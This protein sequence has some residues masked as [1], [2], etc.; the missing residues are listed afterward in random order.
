[1]RKYVALLA[2]IVLPT[3]VLAQTSGKISGVVTDE[4][5]APLGGANVLLVGTTQG[6]A[7]DADGQY[8]VMDVQV[9]VY[10]VRAQYIGYK[11]LTVDNLHVSADLT[12]WLD[13]SLEV[14]ALEGEEVTVTAEKPIINLNATNTNRIIDS[15]VIENLPLRNVQALVNLQTGVVDGHVRGSRDGDNA[16]YVDGVL[17]RNQWNGGNITNGIS[18]SGTQEVSVQTGGFS[19]EYGSANG[20]VVNI[21]SKSGGSAWTGSFEYVTDLGSSP[22]TDPDALYSYGYNLLNFDF[23]G[24][25]TKNT[26]F[27]FNVE[28][29]KSLDYEAAYTTHPEADVYELTSGADLTKIWVTGEPWIDGD[30]EN[31]ASEL[32]EGIIYGEMFVRMNQT[33]PDSLVWADGTEWGEGLPLAAIAENRPDWVDTTYIY[34]DNYSRK[35]GPR[36]NATDEKLALTGN[37][38]F[39]LKPLRIKVGGSMWDREVH[40]NNSTYQLLNSDNQP[41]TE[42]GMKLG[43]INGTMTLSPKSFLRTTL[44]LKDY[45]LEEYNPN[46][47]DDFMAYGKRTADIGSVNYYYR[48]HGLNTL[49]IPALVDYD[50]YG[51]QWNR[52]VKRNE[53]TLGIRTDYLNQIGN[54][55][56][57]GGFEYYNTMIRYYQLSQSREIYQAID[58]LDLNFNGVVDP[59]E[60]TA[61]ADIDDWRYNVYR[62][63]YTYNI[64]Y[65]IFGEE[66]DSYKMADHSMEPGKSVISRIFFA[67]KIEFRDVVLNLGI[68]YETFD[69]NTYGPDSDGDGWA[70]DAG[71]DNVTL[72][73]GRVHREGDGDF[74]RNG[75]TRT[76]E[77]SNKWE[78]VEKYTAI[79]PRIGFSFPVTD[80]TVFHAQY[81]H[82][83]QPAPL[84]FLYLSDSRLAANLTQ[85]NQTASPN[86]T[87]RPERTTSYEIGFTQQMGMSAAIDVTGFYKE[88]RDYVMLKNRGDEEDVTALVDG[89]EFSWAQYMNGDFGVTQGFSFNVNLRRM[90]GVMAAFN[91]TAMWARGTGSDP[92]S[93]WNITWTGDTYPSIINR[94]DYDQRHT[95][96]L[97]V[98]YRTESRNP[99]LA[100]LGLN[101]VM[102]F[103][104]GQAYTPSYDQSAI[105]GRGWWTPTAAIN[106]GDLPWRSQLDLRIDKGFKVGDIKINAYIL[107]VNVLAKLNV[108][109][110]YESTGEAS[111]DGFL[112]TDAG[113]VWLAGQLVSYPSAPAVTLYQDRLISYQNA[114]LDPVRHDVP[115]MLR[116]GLQVEL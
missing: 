105:Y 59:G 46:F 24:P 23:G 78:P 41:V 61:Y 80:M 113:V 95:G 52:Y 86:P 31:G 114:L 110:V 17:V 56:L 29:F 85:G 58:Q 2:L 7:T 38:T 75:V 9:G 83:W 92:L 87:L 35:Y 96:S 76:I 22:G 97:M 115:R 43:F 8:Y 13:F 3:L 55:E 71:F 64:G 94:L 28:K 111:E 67:D 104:S 10:S 48:D 112:Q 79:Q 11:A 50:G 101:A 99:L 89:S 20:G 60:L 15:E 5:G 69:P 100:D 36:Q 19:A 77:G 90:H 37:I 4:N 98:D 70:D 47:G 66:T 68:S 45:Y 40:N 102:T 30:Q 12:T 25:I 27:Y 26:R 54:H 57:K 73:D 72:Y 108:T 6:T 16:Y 18:Q 93:N 39:D 1:M 74:T 32:V 33:N 49:S 44:S 51:A 63:A 34:A 88:V 53:K 84:A 106:S 62:N 103:G 21:T 42:T 65:N 82:Y 109:E 81:G 91:Y 116:V 107:V 14:A